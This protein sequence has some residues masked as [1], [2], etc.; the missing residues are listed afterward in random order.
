MK[1]LN[2]QKRDVQQTIVH[3]Q[4]KPSLSPSQQQEINTSQTDLLERTHRK[5][6]NTMNKVLVSLPINYTKSM[7]TNFHSRNLG[8]NGTGIYWNWSSTTSL[9]TQPAPVDV[10]VDSN[11]I[12]KEN[13]TEDTEL[14]KLYD[15][16]A[17]FDKYVNENNYTVNQSVRIILYCILFRYICTLLLLS[18]PF[19]CAACHWHLSWVRYPPEFEFGEIRITFTFLILDDIQT[20][21]YHICCRILI[22][23]TIVRLPFLQM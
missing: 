22:C 10:A 9:P 20:L 16:M 23:I 19:I 2:V 13:T 4:T 6:P 14:S 1:L 21:K 8:E 3:P 18:V 5:S 17:S 15:M 11:S 12:I 7:P